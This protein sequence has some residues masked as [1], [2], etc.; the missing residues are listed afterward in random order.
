M[1][2]DGYGATPLDNTDLPTA[3]NDSQ[4]TTAALRPLDAYGNCG[5]NLEEDD[6]D[7]DYGKEKSYEIIGSSYDDESQTGMGLLHLSFA[8]LTSEKDEDQ[9]G[10]ELYL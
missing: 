8:R 1:E 5:V 3:S 10:G 9:K 4:V 6:D 7:D 2:D